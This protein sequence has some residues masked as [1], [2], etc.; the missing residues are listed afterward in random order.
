MLKQRVITALVLGA[1][2][3]LAVF[4]LPD[5]LWSVLVA[6]ICVLAV[7]EW[8]SLVKV[9]R[10]GV[11]L[12]M[13][14]CALPLLYVGFLPPSDDTRMLIA[15]G[16]AL[17]VSFWAFSASSL[18]YFGIE[19]VGI[20]WRYTVSLFMFVPAGWAMIELRRTDPWLLI[21]AILIVVIADVAAF[22]TG[23]RFGK[24]KLAP[25]VSPGKTWE[26]VVGACIGV[27]LFCATLWSFVPSIR[28][29]LPLWLLLVLSQVFVALCVL[30]D[31]FESMVKREAGVK[32]SGTLLPGHGGVLDRIDAMIAFLP[33]AGAIEYGLHFFA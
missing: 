25:K 13:L 17:S 28:E 33:L 18:L 4:L 29:T 7:R 5:S 31:L 19:P 30:G 11:W 20:Y 22:F 10:I 16:Y 15:V 3:L 1:V 12:L 23:R 24:R 8:G 32:D 14:I 26:G 27:A 6:A 21:A 9:S 2:L